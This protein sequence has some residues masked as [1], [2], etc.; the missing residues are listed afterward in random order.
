MRLADVRRFFYY[1]PVSLKRAFL[2]AFIVITAAAICV[3]ALIFSSRSRL[4]VSSH[5]S[6]L[7]KSDMT[8][9]VYVYPEMP[10]RGPVILTPAA[11]AQALDENAVIPSETAC[12]GFDATDYENLFSIVFISDE[13]TK[14]S[15]CY[16]AF[17]SAAIVYDAQDEEETSLA[18]AAPS[19]FIRY[20]Y[21]YRIDTVSA[22]TF[23]QHLDQDG[24]DTVIVFSPEKC[25]P[26]LNDD[27]FTIV[28]ES[29]YENAFERGQHVVTVSPDFKKMVRLL[30]NTSG[31]GNEMVTPYSIDM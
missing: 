5:E 11:C 15:L 20:P 18:D 26:L 9:S 8:V 17:P 19:S 1:F 28:T 12:Y 10:A 6:Y 16:E 21:D 13:M 22:Q 30:E 29:I 31:T 4:V 14:W 23:R 24:V 25:L 3:T 2:I 27:T 7:Y